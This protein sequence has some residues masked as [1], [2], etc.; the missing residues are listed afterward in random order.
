MGTICRIHLRRDYT[1]YEWPMTTFNQFFSVF[2]DGVLQH[3]FP[4]AMGSIYNI[5]PGA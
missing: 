5:A 2:W 3:F 4:P 1:Q